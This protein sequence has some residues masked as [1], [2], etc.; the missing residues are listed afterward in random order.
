MDAK[1]HIDNISS[2]STLDMKLKLENMIKNG[3]KIYNFGTIGLR[4]GQHFLSMN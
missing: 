2:S 3:K 1:K 4:F